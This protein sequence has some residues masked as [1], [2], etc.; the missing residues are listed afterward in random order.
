[1]KRT[2]ILMIAAA[3][4]M[5]LAGCFKKVS[6]DTVFIIQPNLQE[7][8]GQTLMPV[9][10]GCEARAWFKRTAKWS[11]ASYDDALANILTDTE[12]GNTESAEPDALSE[13]WEDYGVSGLLRIATES[14]SVL[15]VVLYPEERMFAWR[16]YKTAENLSPVNLKFQFRPWRYKYDAQ[17]NAYRDGDWNVDF[18]PRTA[19]P[20]DNDNTEDN[21]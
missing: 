17:S 11:V 14:S 18:A 4:A 10:E 3:A 2:A 8:S 12:N 7:E 1:M 16:V 15:L 13:P 6:H 5:M 21:E 9:A 20:A 19:P